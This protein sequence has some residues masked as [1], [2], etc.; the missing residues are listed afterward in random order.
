MIFIAL[1]TIL[2]DTESVTTVY[3]FLQD[4]LLNLIIF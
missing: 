3:M 2:G 4:N 1:R